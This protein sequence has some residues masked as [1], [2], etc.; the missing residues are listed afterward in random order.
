METVFIEATQ[1]PGGPNWG[2]FAVCRFTPGEAARPSAVDEGPLL[3]RC[4]WWQPRG[5]LWVL[6][7]QTGE[8]AF[9]QPGGHAH[10][11]LEKH[12]IWVCPLFEPFLEWLYGQDLSDLAGLPARV[13][14]PAAGFAFHGHRRPG[15][16]KET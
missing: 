12:A 16:R 14:L 3:A 7:L 15:P 6:D 11:D 5:R 13:E 1:G 8:G 4:G 9:F 10:A 2:K